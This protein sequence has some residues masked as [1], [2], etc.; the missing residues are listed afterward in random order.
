MSSSTMLS[1]HI[2]GRPWFQDNVQHVFSYSMFNII[3]QHIYLPAIV[4]QC[5]FTELFVKK[6]IQGGGDKSKCVHAC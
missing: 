6:L 1:E 3:N 2:L 4:S 5:N